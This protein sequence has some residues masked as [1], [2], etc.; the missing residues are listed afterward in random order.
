MNILVLNLNFYRYKTFVIFKSV[1]YY[2]GIIWTRFR[3]FLTFIDYRKLSDDQAYVADKTK[4]ENAAVLIINTC[5]SY[6]IIIVG[7]RWELMMPNC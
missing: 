4:G 2:I 5:C 7:P 3:T 6:Q 1:P